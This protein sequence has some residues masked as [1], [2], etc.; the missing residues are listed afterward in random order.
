MGTSKLH[1]TG[2]LDLQFL[3][4]HGRW[5]NSVMQLALCYNNLRQAARYLVIDL[6][7]QGRR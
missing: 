1:I 3:L 4:N 7:S 6:L 5:E 2:Q